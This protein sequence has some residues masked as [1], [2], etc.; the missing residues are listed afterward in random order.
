MG[1]SGPQID[2]LKCSCPPLHFV[3]QDWM[4]FESRALWDAMEGKLTFFLR[5]GRAWAL[6]R[7]SEVRAALALLISR[8]QV[9]DRQVTLSTEPD[10][11]DAYI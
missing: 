3:S 5:E 4:F 2:S 1:L 6:D 9:L 7:S 10:E 11:Q 8:A